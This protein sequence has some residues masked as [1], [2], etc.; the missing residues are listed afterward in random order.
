MKIRKATIKDFKNLYQIGLK[1]P[2]LR[3]SAS[4][5][6]MEKDDFKLRIIDKKHV[7]LV[8]EDQNKIVGFICANT[9]DKDRPLKHKWACIV[10]IAV[11]PDNRNQGV[12]TKL[13]HECAKI[14]K[15]RGI[16]HAYALADADTKAIQ[17]FL[18]KAGFKSGER[19]VWMDRKL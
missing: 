17:R 19:M 8:A 1:T 13:Y 18:K 9:G 11:V 15:K 10:Y 5:P 4:T 6:F 12:A 7:F 14:L 3:V 16:T 2:E